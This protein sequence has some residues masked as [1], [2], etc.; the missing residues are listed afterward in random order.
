MVDVKGQ[1]LKIKKDLDARV[2][3]TIESGAFIQG[4]EVKLFESALGGLLDDVEVVGCANGTD[5]LQIALMALGLQPGDEVIVPSFTFV[6]SV[7]VIVLLGMVPV[8]VDVDPET[9]LMR[10][11][12]IEASLSPKTKAIIPVHLFGQCV[13]MKSVMEIAEKNNLYVIEDNAQAIGARCADES[14]E[15]KMAGTIGHIGCTSFYPS[16]NLG[17]YGDGGAVMSRDTALVQRLKMLANHGM[18][19]RYYHDA[20]GVNSRLDSI[21]AAILNV[22]L[23]HLKKWNAQR[24]EAAAKYDAQLAGIEFLS[25]PKRAASSE[26]IFHQYTLRIKDGSRNAL[27]KHLADKEIP[28]MIYYPV[29]MHEQGAYKEVVQCRVPLTHT[30]MISDEV[31]SLPMHPDLTD[32]QIQYICDHI[33]AFFSV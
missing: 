27:Q 18:E 9:F 17:C 4:P 1:Y 6:A 7:E 24:Q 11:E 25:T 16:K 8:V 21:Q 31:L 13:D 22:K 14:G 23:P 33:K 19:R 3:A 26:H 15:M 30:N 2:I 12:D 29:P 5:A 28:S 32:E 10:T 20:I